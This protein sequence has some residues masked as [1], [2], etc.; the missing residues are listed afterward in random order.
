VFDQPVEYGRPS[1]KLAVPPSHESEDRFGSIKKRGN[2]GVDFSNVDAQNA[3]TNPHGGANS[4]LK[5][6]SISVRIIPFESSDYF[7]NDRIDPA[8]YD[9]ISGRRALAPSRPRCKRKQR[10]LAYAEN[11][12]IRNAV[13]MNFLPWLAT[14]Y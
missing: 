9:D 10:F 11:V 2:Q 12:S 14:K 3:K 6:K 8:P 1:W 4:L 13:R 7:K 5:L